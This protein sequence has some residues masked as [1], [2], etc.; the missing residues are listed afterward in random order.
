M[1][2]IIASSMRNNVFTGDDGNRSVDFGKHVLSAAAINDTVDLQVIPAGTKLVGVSLVNA[3]LGSL[4]TISLGWRNKDGTAGGSAT[5]L[6]A[7]TSTVAAAKTNSVFAPIVFNQ[8]AVL[9]ATVGGGVAT[10][11][12]DTITDYL[13]QGTL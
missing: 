3:A 8:D 12:I 9:Y 13:F 7:A 1:A 11:Q 5:A 2:Q 4:T 6:L 10:G